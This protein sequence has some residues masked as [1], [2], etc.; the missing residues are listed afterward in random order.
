MGKHYKKAAVDP[1][2]AKKWLQRHEEEKESIPQI[3]KADFYD[4]RTVRRQLGLMKQDREN[5]E[6]R[7]E[8]LRAA[9]E[10]HYDDLC[11]FARKLNREVSGMVPGEISVRTREDPLWTAMRQHLPRL[12]VW[13]DLEKLSSLAKEFDATVDTL[14]RHIAAECRSRL[15][16]EFTSQP[17]TIGLIDGVV[18][19]LIWHMQAVARGERGLEIIGYR[20]LKSKAGVRVGKGAFGLAEVADEA[21]A[22]R[23]EKAFDSLMVEALDWEDYASLKSYTEHYLKIKKGVNE[24]M[25]RIKLRRVVPGRCSYCP[26]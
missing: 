3:A 17:D 7:R 18:F 8:V 12:P 20:R 1:E 14:K 4:V 23:V 15:L 13:R 19:G 16:L 5:Q 25:T 9:L 10:K 6:A 2:V 22:A 26:I 11:G 21:E 24:E